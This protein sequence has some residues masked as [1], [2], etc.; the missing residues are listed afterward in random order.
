HG[1][2]LD[3]VTRP[4]CGLTTAT[5]LYD[6]G[7]P[8]P[9]GPVCAAN[10]P[11]YEDGAVAATNP[12]VVLWFSSWETSDTVE[13][14]VVSHFGTLEGD[15]ALLPGRAAA[16]GRLTAGGAR[17]LLV[18]GPAPADTS[19]VQVSRPD[20]GARRAHLTALFWIYALRHPQD[21]AVVD[22]ARIVCP[23]SDT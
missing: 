8:V 9:W 5:P 15:A 1:V 21:V 6:T 4:G 10:V 2:E 23:P 18:T 16:R 14:G 12:D 7:E 11:A 20:E 13:N 19:E 22:L 3:A 17:L